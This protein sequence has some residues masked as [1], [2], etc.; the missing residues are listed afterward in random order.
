MKLRLVVAYDGTAFRGWQ[1]QRSGGT[2]QDALETAVAGIIGS[3]VPVH[4]SG[5]TDAGV[6]ALAQTAHV[7]LPPEVI[8]GLRRMRDAGRW[9]GAF[10]DALPPQLR[11]L[12]CSWARRDFHARY[13]ATGKI[14]R[15]D[16]W[17]APALPPHLYERIWHIHGGLDRQIIRE[18]AASIEGSHDFRGFCAGSVSLPDNTVRTLRSVTIRERGARLRFVF[19]GDG[20]LYR[21]V[22]MLVGGIIRVAQGKEKASSF[23]A[24]LH[25]GK[26]WPTPAMAPAGGL[27]LV[28]ALYGKKAV[29]PLLDH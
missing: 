29:L 27:Y 3:R 14:Y 12:R 21:M 16:I 24:R 20:F 4:G 6:H 10:N 11:V 22:R 13:S 1:S 18:L 2:V 25:A 9:I 28:R 15:Y 8:P 7:E 5:R 17:Q 26:P 23:T 19:Q